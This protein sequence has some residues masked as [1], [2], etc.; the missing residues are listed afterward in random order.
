MEKNK[1]T[2]SSLASLPALTAPMMYCIMI[3]DDASVCPSGSVRTATRPDCLDESDAATEL[4]IKCSS[5]IASL[6]LAMVSSDTLGYLL[7]T[8]ETVETATP[9]LF[10]TSLIVT[11]KSPPLHMMNVH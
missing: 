5:S 1:G 6:T 8:L 4:G 11:I 3:S 2:I 10:A 9:A 7:M